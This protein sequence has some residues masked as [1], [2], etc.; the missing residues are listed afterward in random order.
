MFVGLDVFLLRIMALNLPGLIIISFF[1]N[2]S[3][4][5]LLCNSNASI[6]LETVSPRA[7]SVLSPGKLSQ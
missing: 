4:A 6:N 7:E 1:V 2:Q 5:I 3:I